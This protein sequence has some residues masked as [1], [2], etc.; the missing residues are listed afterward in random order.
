M[1]SDNQWLFKSKTFSLMA[2]QTDR[3]ALSFYWKCTGPLKPP[4]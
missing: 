4:K 1:A 2:F 3:S